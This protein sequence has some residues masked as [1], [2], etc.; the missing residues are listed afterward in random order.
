MIYRE[1][2]LGKEHSITVC[3]DS[4]G[5][6]STM[7]H[8]KFFGAIRASKRNHTYRKVGLFG[9]MGSVDREKSMENVKE[10]I[11]QLNQEK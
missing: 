1:V 8:S 6:I 9:M 4:K 3:E 2:P 10:Y 7:L 5:N 11:K